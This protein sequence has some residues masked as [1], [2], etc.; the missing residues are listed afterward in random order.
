MQADQVWLNDHNFFLTGDY[1]TVLRGLRRRDP[2]HWT[3]GMNGWNFWSLTR[4]EDCRMVCRNP[5]RFCSARG[6][7]L[8]F[9]PREAGPKT[10]DYGN[11][12]MLIST[13]PPRHNRVRKVVSA[14]F[15]PRAIGLREARFVA[16]AD[17]LI[18]EV[19]PR[20]RCDLVVELAA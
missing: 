5:E 18:D 17:E 7:V 20:G 9:E 8:P 3:E 19:A 13:D 11:G 14:A 15:T 2:V 4:Y 12:L 1:D 6:I 10:V 16:I